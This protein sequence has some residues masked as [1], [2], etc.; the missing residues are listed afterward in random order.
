MDFVNSKKFS[1]KNEGAGGSC[2][3]FKGP[4]LQGEQI[5]PVGYF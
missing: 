1:R 5:G 2:I 3:I 4:Y